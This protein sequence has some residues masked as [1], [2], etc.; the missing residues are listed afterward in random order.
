MKAHLKLL[1]VEDMEDD[2]MLVLRALRAGGFQ[3]AH[4]RVWTREALAE[5]LDQQPWDIV[6]SDYSMPGFDGPT[7]LRIVRERVGDLPFIIVSGTVGED[8]TV[9]AMKA[10]AHDYVMKDKLARLSVSVERELREAR[11]RRERRGAEKLAEL[12]RRDKE[13]A[14]AANQAKSR[15]LANMSHELR[16]PLNA[17]IGFSEL[18]EGGVAGPLSEK[19]SE[20]MGHVLSSSRHLLAL[21]TDILDLSK[22]EAG[23][24]ELHIEPTS[25]SETASLV[26][27]IVKPLAD[28]QGL[29]LLLKLD[30]ELPAL[31]ADPIRLKQILYNL[32][33]NAIKFTPRGGV[34]SLEAR[35]V[36]DQAQ[37][38][39]SDTGVGI[40][41]EDLPRLFHEFEQLGKDQEGHARGTGLGLALTKRLIEQHAGSVTVESELGHGTKFTVQMPVAQAESPV[42]GITKLA[43]ERDLRTKSPV[44]GRVLVV[45]DDRHSRQFVRELLEFQGHEVLEA[46]DV[47]S[48]KRELSKGPSLVIT[49]ISLRGGGGESLLAYV[50]QN[51]GKSV[52]VLATTAHAMCGDRERILSAGFDAYMSKPIHGRDLGA[53]VTSMLRR[54][55]ASA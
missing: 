8:M 20:F 6:I 21:I 31:A 16:T 51:E 46:H 43:P 23:K 26:H 14:D 40:A 48:A 25:L 17:I 32:L 35:L 39:V 47:E 27:T 19:Q 28:K 4:H 50:R 10:G 3:V 7:A 38:V 12:A 37:I 36:A 49:D 54:A 1:L 53:L 33:S 13:R 11:A 2:A 5:A 55:R 18:M 24:M 45:E 42:T 34:V 15:F 44:K 29:S 9:A 52:K 22:V 41:T 30:P